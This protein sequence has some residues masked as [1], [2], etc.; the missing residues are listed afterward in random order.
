[1]GLRSG[2]NL[3][4]VEE[5]LEQ[6][7]DEAPCRCSSKGAYAAVLEAGWNGITEILL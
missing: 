6:I 3:D 4:N 1:M 2:L 5:L 7:E